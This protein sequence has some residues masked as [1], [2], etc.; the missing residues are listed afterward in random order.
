MLVPTPTIKKELERNIPVGRLGMPED[1]L[2][3]GTEASSY[4]TG[5]TIKV[6][7]EGTGRI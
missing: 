5:E 7:G 2:Y 1:L 3:L 4:A 6:L